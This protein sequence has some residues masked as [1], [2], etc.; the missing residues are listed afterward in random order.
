MPR[1]YKLRISADPQASIVLV[2]LILTRP[3]HW[4]LAWFVAACTHEAFHCIGVYI[5]GGRIYHIKIGLYGARI[6]T[7]ALS[8]GKE[9]VCLLAGPLG[10]LSCLLFVRYL[11]RISICAV[12]QSAYNLL[13]LPDFDGG[14]ALHRILLTISK[15]LS[16]EKTCKIIQYIT[17][18]LIIMFCALCSIAWKMGILPMVLAMIFLMRYGKIKIPCKHGR[19]RVQ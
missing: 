15:P 10:T 4:V 19:H 3:I 13:P 16:A 12:L 1:L 7:S 8:V 9:I 14:K 17:I 11:P 5:C 6:E 2:V 18:L